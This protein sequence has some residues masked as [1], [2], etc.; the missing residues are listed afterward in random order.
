MRTGYGKRNRLA[1]LGLPNIDLG[2]RLFYT[3]MT[4]GYDKRSRLAG[5]GLPNT[6]LDSRDSCTL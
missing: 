5:L 6:D 4:T 3:V 2:S 1:G